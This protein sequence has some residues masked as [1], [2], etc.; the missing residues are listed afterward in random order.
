MAEKGF[1]VAALPRDKVVTFLALVREKEIRAKRNGSFYLHLLLGDRIGDLEAK[2][3]DCPQETAGLFERDDIVKVRGAI[4]LYNG[5]PQ[6]IV[7]RIRRCDEGEFQ[8]VDFCAARL[9]I[10]RRCSPSCE[11]LQSPSRTSTCARSCSR[12]SMTPSSHQRSRLHPAQ[13]ACIMPSELAF[14]T[15][16]CRSVSWL[17]CWSRSTRDSTAIG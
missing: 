12:F 11:G 17:R 13:C 8:E 3:W 5:R 6:L 2:A 1:F 9:A 15:I 7:Q 16:H 14:S 4:E 10:R